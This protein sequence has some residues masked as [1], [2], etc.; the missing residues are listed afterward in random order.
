MTKRK[1]SA[2][3]VLYPEANSEPQSEANGSA[4]YPEAGD[5]EPDPVVTPDELADA[6]VQ[7]LPL[8][9][10]APA[11]VAAPPPAPPQRQR[12]ISAEVVK[13]ETKLIQ[14]ERSRDESLRNHA[15]SWDAKRSAYI[16]ALPA[17]VRAALV[18]MRVLE[19]GED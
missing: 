7:A 13:A 17:D 8:P 15:Q 2:L 3:A 5:T 6:L 4:S 9:P 18:A 10:E 16:S 14:I 11:P 19:P 1:A 12:R